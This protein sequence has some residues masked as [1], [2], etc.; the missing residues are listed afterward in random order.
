[1]ITSENYCITPENLRAHELI[2]LNAKVQNSTD[3]SRKGISG[4]VIDETRNT[5]VIET[6]DG[7]KKIPKAEA[8]FVF[9]LGNENAELSGK[10]ILSRPEDRIKNFWRKRNARM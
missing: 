8:E 6:K 10:D 2:G 1:M 4:L 3:P 9:R 7:A 5:I